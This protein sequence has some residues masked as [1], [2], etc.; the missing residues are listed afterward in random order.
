LQVLT[1]QQADESKLEHEDVG[2]AVSARTFLGVDL[3][4]SINVVP[5]SVPND[6]YEQLGGQGMNILAQDKWSAC[7]R[8]LVP[9]WNR[10]V[11]VDYLTEFL[12]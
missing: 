11:Y 5:N 7:R 6:F 12:M 3:E 10:I 8:S 9:A 4:S 2:Q 1:R